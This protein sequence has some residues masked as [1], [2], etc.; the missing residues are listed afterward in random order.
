MNAVAFCHFA[1]PQKMFINDTP[2]PELVRFL[3]QES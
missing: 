2:V 1:D 3:R